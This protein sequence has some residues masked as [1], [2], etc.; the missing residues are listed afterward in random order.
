MITGHSV[1]VCKKYYKIPNYLQ[2]TKFE[3]ISTKGK[4]ILKFQCVNQ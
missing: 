1:K 2:L 3:I 4:N